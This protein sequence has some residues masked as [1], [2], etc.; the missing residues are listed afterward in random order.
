MSK[1]LSGY[2]G[3]VKLLLTKEK[4]LNI[5]EDISIIHEKDNKINRL[6]NELLRHWILR[7]KLQS[8]KRKVL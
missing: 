8:I 3:D 6:K 1:I 7:Q 4:L 5:S 2:S